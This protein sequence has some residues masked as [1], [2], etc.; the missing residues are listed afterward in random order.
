MPLSNVTTLVLV[1]D[2]LDCRE[3]VKE[4]SEAMFIDPQTNFGYIIQKVR[5]R[6][7]KK[8]PVIFK[9]VYETRIIHIRCKSYYTQL[10]IEKD[11]KNSLIFQFDAGIQNPQFASEIE[12][13]L[14]DETILGFETE[15]KRVGNIPT[16][17]ISN[18]VEEDD[19]PNF[20]TGGDITTDGTRIFLRN[21]KSTS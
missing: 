15:L 6:N 13:G 5:E 1:D 17:S 20:V 4:D 12:T 2:K 8:N 19:L 9:V 10:H 3:S 14:G 21:S 16:L 11:K 18:L 7:A